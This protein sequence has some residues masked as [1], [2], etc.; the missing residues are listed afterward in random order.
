M[1]KLEQV[2]RIG[3]SIM[4]SIENAHAILLLLSPRAARN[5]P[6]EIALTTAAPVSAYDIVDGE[7]DQF[8]TFNCLVSVNTGT[9]TIAFKFTDYT[10]VTVGIE[11]YVEAYF[12][13]VFKL[14]AFHLRVATLNY[15]SPSTFIDMNGEHFICDYDGGRLLFAAED[16]VL[17][18][19]IVRGDA[20]EYTFGCGI[21]YNQTINKYVSVTI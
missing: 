9:K 5:Q 18:L 14:P 15:T 6:L 8:Y 10:I 1:I 19:L 20:L 21:T 12:K 4:F 2:F 17:K 3:N 13:Q 11:E 16:G 7:P